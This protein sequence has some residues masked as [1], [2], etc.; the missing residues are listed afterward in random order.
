MAS[1]NWDSDWLERT[2]LQALLIRCSASAADWAHPWNGV[3]WCKW[4]GFDSNY[5]DRARATNSNRRLA[6]NAA[7]L[8]RLFIT[9]F[10]FFDLIDD[11]KFSE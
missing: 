3:S 6:L 8:L 11:G 1:K 5:V 4:M 2:L 10:A 7:V 9:Q